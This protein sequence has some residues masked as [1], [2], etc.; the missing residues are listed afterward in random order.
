MYPEWKPE[1][2]V[3]AAVFHN[4]HEADVARSLL[5]SFDVECVLHD[6]FIHR[7]HPF[8]A[9]VFGGLRLQVMQKDL[10]LAQELLKGFTP[11][12]PMEPPEP[13]E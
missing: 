4:V 8:S 6:Q 1:D 11:A 10:E 9:E 2:L 3:T 12:E 13:I 5:E 7:V